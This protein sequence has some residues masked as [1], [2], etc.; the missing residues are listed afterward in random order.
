MSFFPTTFEGL[1]VA[2]MCN[3]SESMSVLDCSSINASL[4]LFF[5]DS[6]ILKRF[7]DN[8]FAFFADEHALKQDKRLLHFT[9]VDVHQ[10]T[11]QREHNRYTQLIRDFSKF[12][13]TTEVIPS[14]S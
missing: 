14:K 8:C 9:V 11:F 10:L 1:V 2:K 13:I 5:D 4:G 3:G 6:C 7:K 12:P